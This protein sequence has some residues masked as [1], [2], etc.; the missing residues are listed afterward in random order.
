MTGGDLNDGQRRQLLVLYRAGAYSYDNAMPQ[1]MLAEFNATAVALLERLGLVNHRAAR[2][3]GFEGREYYL[4]A[5]GRE[6][7]GELEVAS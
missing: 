3:G 4:L 7:A 6:L 1:E 5:A 2:G